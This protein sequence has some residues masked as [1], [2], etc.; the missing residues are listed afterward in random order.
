MEPTINIGTESISDYLNETDVN[1]N[2]KNKINKKNI[3]KQNEAP[4][5]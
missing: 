4:L 1:L 2:L 5:S 3:A